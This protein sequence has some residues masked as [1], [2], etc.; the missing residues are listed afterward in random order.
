MLYRD[1]LESEIKKDEKD[2]K[3]EGD[4]ALQK[5]FKGI[6]GDADEDTRRAMNKSFQVSPRPPP[7][8]LFPP[9]PPP[10]C[11]LQCCHAFVKEYDVG[12]SQLLRVASLSKAPQKRSC[13]SFALKGLAKRHSTM[14][15]HL[16][17]L[18]IQLLCNNKI[19]TRLM[20]SKL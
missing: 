15:H 5:L 20:L 9:T 14:P 13:T 7:P 2:E 11:L 18:G 4:A 12:A 16:A 1:K 17:V 8:S 6:Y 19:E 10:L 3:L